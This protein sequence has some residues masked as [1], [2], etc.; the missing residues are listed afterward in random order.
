MVWLTADA[1]NV[2]VQV[3]TAVPAPVPLVIGA[4]GAAWQ[5]A[6]GFHVPDDVNVTEPEG[7]TGPV[8]AG[9]TVAVKVTGC[10][11]TLTGNEDTK[12]AVACPAVTTCENTGE[13]VVE[14]LGSP[15]LYVAVIECVVAVHF[16]VRLW[17]PTVTAQDAVRF[18]TGTSVHKVKPVSVSLN[19]TVEVGVAPEFGRVKVA[20]K[21]TGWFTKVAPCTDFTA[22]VRFAGLTVWTSAVAPE[23]L[24]RKFESPW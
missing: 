4:T 24:P 14:K 9:V 22:I 6:A 23:G 15:L 1:G 17:F 21:V 11:A 8:C 5:I 18:E 10:V 16:S 19:D 3:A 20:V 2:A 13:F 7:T 12:A